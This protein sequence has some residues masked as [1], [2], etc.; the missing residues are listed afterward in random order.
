MTR[1]GKIIIIAALAVF[2]LLQSRRLAL[3]WINEFEAAFQEMIAMHHLESGIKANH[4][5]P[6]IAQ[7]DGKKFY[8]T[9]HPPLLHIIY[10]VL[11]RIFG[12]HEWVTRSISITLLIAAI[13]LLSRLIEPRQRPAFF[14]IALFLPVSFRL[15]ITTNYEPLTIFSVSLFVFAFE[16]FRMSR[17]KNYCFFLLV[18]FILMLLSDWPAYLAIPALIL[19]NLRRADERKWLLILLAAEVAF[20][21]AFLFYQKSIAGEIALFSHGLTRSNPLYIFQLATYQEMLEHLVWI[22]GRPALILAAAALAKLARDRKKLPIPD[23]YAFSALFLLLLWLT[24]ANL[25]SRHYVYLLYFFPLLAMALSYVATALKSRKLALALVLVSFLVPD[26]KGFTIRDARAFYLAAKVSK[27]GA[28]T[29]F[30]SAALG[31][32]FF[33]DKIET[34]VPVS[35]DA[36]LS[37]DKIEFDL[38][39][40]DQKSAEVKKNKELIERIN[41]PGYRLVWAFPDLSVYLKKNLKLQDRYLAGQLDYQKRGARWWEPTAEVVWFQEKP[42]YGIKQPPGPQ[43]ISRLE[44]ESRSECLRLRPAII[45]SALS[46]KSDGVGFTVIGSG[47]EQKNLLY[48]RFLVSAAAR[49]TEIPVGN[50]NRIALITDAGPKGNYSFDDAFWL[51]AAFTECEAKE[52]Q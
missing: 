10:A 33:Y 41:S 1:S 4:F 29:C 45:R 28:R 23:L 39:V 20:L 11:Y 35:E 22:L 6:V 50:L 24:A 12:V 9:A 52:A 14:I 43:K 15:G 31:T 44:F 8:H 42:W 51:D 5:L 18:S 32:L 38:L 13:F 49:E 3:P 47:P 26:Y 7:I 37:L 16:R 30:S 19:I 34:M 27:T 17:K 2:L 36:S 25:A 46:G 40:V 21:A 48:S